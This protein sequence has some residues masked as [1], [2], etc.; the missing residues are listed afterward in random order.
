M[1]IDVQTSPCR[2]V[3]LSYKRASG[4]RYPFHTT[5]LNET[6]LLSHCPFQVGCSNH[7]ASH[8][9]LVWLGLVICSCV[10][11]NWTSPDMSILYGHDRVHSHCYP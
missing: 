11:S 6:K 7:G 10:K 3:G 9:S 4:H 2:V 1:Y 5:V 8:I